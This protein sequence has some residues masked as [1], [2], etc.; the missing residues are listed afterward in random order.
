M[1]AKL[2]VR[3]WSGVLAGLAYVAVNG[4]LALPLFSRRE[5]SL[6]STGDI[7]SVYAGV[8][9]SFALLCAFG[10]GV[11]AIVR[12]QVGAIIAAI[13]FFFVLSPLPE[14]LPGNIGD[15]FPAQA[16]G[17]LHGLPEA[18]EG[19]LSQVAGGLVLAAWSPSPRRAR[20]ILIAAATSTISGLATSAHQ[21]GSTRQSIEEAGVVGADAV[22][23]GLDQLAA[24]CGRSST[25][26][27]I[28]STPASSRD[29]CEAAADQRVVDPHRLDPEL[30]QLLARRG[31]AGGWRIATSAA[32][33]GAFAQRFEVQSLVTLG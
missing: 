12:N 17:S 13:A 14:L 29:A 18:T 3:C 28:S 11:G 32:S 6:P 26:Q 8:V 23:A 19:G 30:R 20:H 15:Y 33:I 4:G 9:V 27:A 5:G 1:L 31:R 25:V 10:L 24:C 16:I 22:D 2:G 21:G 7:V